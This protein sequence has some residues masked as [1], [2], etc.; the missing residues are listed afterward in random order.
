MKYFLVGIKGSGM[1]ALAVILKELG[2][3]VMGS[4]IE[5]FVFTQVNLERHQ[6]NVVPFDTVSLA[7]FDCVIYGNSFDDN[8]SEVKQAHDL[9]IETVRYTGFLKQLITQYNSICIAGTHGKTTTTGMMKTMLSGFAK[10]GYLI[11]DGDGMIEKDAHYFVVESCEYQDNFLNY[12]PDYVVINNVEL[13][14]VDYFKS[15]EAYI[16]SFERFANQAKKAVLVL[17][18]DP[19]IQKLKIHK[20]IFTFGLDSKADLYAKNCVFST[21]G[22]TFDLYFETVLLKKVELPFY[23]KHML[24]NSLAV[25]LMGLVEGYEIEAIIRNLCAFEGV[26]RRF[27]IETV[28]DSELID[29]YAHHPTA[30]KLMIETSRQ[31][32]PDKQ[33]VAIFKP[34]RYSRLEQFVD[35][36]A[37]ALKGA[38]HVFL[39]DFAPNIIRE[40]GVTITIQ[41]LQKRISNSKI[42]T[43]DEA[44]AK[45]LLDLAPNT[46]LFMSSKNIYELKNTLKVLM[47]S[48]L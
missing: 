16:E 13:D 31:K 12:F 20:P 27:N 33:V 37:D 17:Y 39:C 26:N 45:Q 36:F 24:L 22:M 40:P 14:H 29:D 1:S 46:F 3:D 43:Q 4:D 48:K 34:D 47:D 32:F 6:I 35:D 42:I 15:L 44:G 11:G 7:D 30:I 21:S 9:K 10:T 2:H 19:N 18:D 5:Q 25:I 28:K 8:F 41:D 23:G 38:D